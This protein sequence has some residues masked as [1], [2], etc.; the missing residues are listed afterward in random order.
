MGVVTSWRWSSLF[1]TKVLLS[2]FKN[3]FFVL[4]CSFA[5]SRLHLNILLRAKD[6]F[7]LSFDCL[8]FISNFHISKISL[9]TGRDCDVHST[10]AHT[11]TCTSFSPFSLAPK[12]SLR[13]QNRWMAHFQF[14]NTDF[15]IST[16]K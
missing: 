10:C 6:G 9:K 2:S 13:A 3:L 4:R 1:F 8:F 16:T 15:N 5:F 11:H 12:I 14:Q 7:L